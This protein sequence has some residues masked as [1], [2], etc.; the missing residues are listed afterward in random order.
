L[1]QRWQSYLFFVSTATLAALY[2]P[3]RLPEYYWGW[4]FLI[5]AAIF[6]WMVAVSHAVVSRH[7]IVDRC[8]RWWLALV[9][10]MA[11]LAALVFVN[12][13]LIASGFHLYDIPSTSMEPT[14]V[15]GDHIVADLWYYRHQQPAAGDLVIAKREGIVIVKRVM[16]V[17]GNTIRGDDTVIYVNEKKLEEPYV[18]HVGYPQDQLDTFG[19]VTVPAGK[20]FVMGDNREVSLDSRTGEVGPIDVTNV[21]GKALYIFQSDADRTGRT[22]H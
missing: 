9:L 1:G 5:F 6:L 19:P 17:G 22:L 18:S 13:A 12:R 14:I 20:L 15:R 4:V 21:I 10:P 3:A 7:P 8:S 16:A 2:W 11:F